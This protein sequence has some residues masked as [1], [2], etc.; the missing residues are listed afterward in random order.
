M[1]N[2]IDCTDPEN[3]DDSDHR[4]KIEI[5]R[6]YRVSLIETAYGKELT[7]DSR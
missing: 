3:P 1:T 4:I 5:T 2:R 6:V 7:I